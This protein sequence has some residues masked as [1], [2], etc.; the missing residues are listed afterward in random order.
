MSRA[1][2]ILI[3]Y[4]LTSVVGCLL[5]GWLIRR[6]RNA[7]DDYEIVVLPP[8]APPLRPG[9]PEWARMGFDS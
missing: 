5:L 3:A 1:A 9:A 2:K 7:W 8:V 6:G 4:A